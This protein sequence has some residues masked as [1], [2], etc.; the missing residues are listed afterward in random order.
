MI[1]CG[2]KNLPGFLPACI[3]RFAKAIAGHLRSSW[4]EPL[5]IFS[6]FTTP[7][8]WRIVSIFRRKS[9]LCSE[10]MGVSMT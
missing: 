3:T 5:H 10:K 2:S 7:S 6:D 8:H 1:R 9:S 4:R